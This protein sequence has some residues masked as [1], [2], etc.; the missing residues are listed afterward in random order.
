MNGER[1]VKV[2]CLSGCNI[3][4]VNKVNSYSRKFSSKT[5]V[6]SLVTM[7]G[8]GY[9]HILNA[10]EHGLRLGLYFIIAVALS[11]SL[12]LSVVLI[13][14]SIKRIIHG[15]RCRAKKKS[16]ALKKRNNLPVLR[17]AGL[18]DKKRVFPV[19]KVGYPEGKKAN[20]QLID[21]KG[22]IPIETSISSP[23]DKEE[24]RHQTGKDQEND[25]SE[26]GC[27]DYDAKIQ[28]SLTRAII[29][30]ENHMRDNR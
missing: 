19:S 26:L 15:I 8:P 18:D 28:K 1:V 9:T 16:L 2:P 17:K 27:V 20:I 24:H 3:L 4:T 14:Y 6:L 10:T 29:I 22:L 5:S 23:I 25:I 30:T 7:S 12:I 13:I 11:A 21:E